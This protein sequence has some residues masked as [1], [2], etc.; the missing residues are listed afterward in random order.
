MT[1][2]KTQRADKFFSNTFKMNQ[3]IDNFYETGTDTQNM[4]WYKSDKV[5]RV[6]LAV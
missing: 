3:K 5:E 6:Q 2:E 1:N 4:R